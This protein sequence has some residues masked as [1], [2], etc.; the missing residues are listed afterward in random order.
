MILQP[1]LTPLLCKIMFF[2][3]M[4]QLCRCLIFEHCFCSFPL[5]LIIM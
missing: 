1:E 2:L 3:L 5:L 4:F